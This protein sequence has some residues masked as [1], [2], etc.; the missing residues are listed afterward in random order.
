MFPVF[1]AHAEERAASMFTTGPS[2][3]IA[4]G[5][6][7]GEALYHASLD[8]AEYQSLLEQHGFGI[9]STVAQD[10]D[11]G[12]RTVWLAQQVHK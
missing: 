1:R 7:E 10:T 2:N 6:L 12:G 5:R 3:G 8:P 11:C 4:V 9:V